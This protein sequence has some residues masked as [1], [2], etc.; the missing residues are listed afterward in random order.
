MHS[1][2]YKCFFISHKAPYTKDRMGSKF[3]IGSLSIVMTLLL[4]LVPKLE[5]AF[6]TVEQAIQS[7][8]S[9][10]FLVIGDWGR[11]GLYNQSQVALQM[12]KIGEKMDIDFVV[13]TGDNIYDNGM[14]SIDDP[15]FQL[16]FVNIYTSPSLQKPW[17][18][19]LGNHDYRGDVEAQLSPAL[20]SID[21]R[22]ICMRSF[23]VDAEIAELFFVD[24]TPFVDAYFLNPEGQNYDW[25]GVSPR[26]SYLQ[27]TLKDLEK[28]LRESTAKWKIV[29]GHH[30]IKSASIHGN[31]KEL[32]SLLLPIL[33][34]NNVDLY[35]NGHDHCLQHISTSQSSLRVLISDNG[36]Y[37]IVQVVF[38]PCLLPPKSRST[39][40]LNPS[41]PVKL[42]PNPTSK[43]RGFLGVS[44]IKGSIFVL[45][46]LCGRIGVWVRRNVATKASIEMSHFELSAPSAVLNSSKKQ[47]GPIIVIDNY[48]KLHLQSLPG[49]DFRI[50]IYASLSA[51]MI[52]IN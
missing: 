23:I 7:D 20:R 21:S 16:S 10:S 51:K 38:V 41:S 4:S 18:L 19:V 13:S 42:S 43:S 17:Y 3:G 40:R 14:K 44:R 45:F 15:A 49:F 32:E 36:G 12:G 47:K 52:L 50:L 8:G 5:A 1:R 2:L 24:T 27:T 6:T 9:I 48:E 37:D 39:T 26:E 35:V 34:A 31:T 28:S 30:A 46:P 11:R 29:V 22:W 25:R 33:E